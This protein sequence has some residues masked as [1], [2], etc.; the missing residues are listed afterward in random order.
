MS[1]VPRFLEYTPEP[2]DLRD[3]GRRFPRHHVFEPDDVHA[4][5]AA[6]ASG[7]P[8]LLRGKPGTGKSQLALAAAVNTVSTAKS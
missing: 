4:V 3:E 5:N 7:R 2:V 1:S 6:L 8:L